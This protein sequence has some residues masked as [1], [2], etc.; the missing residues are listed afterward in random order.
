MPKP[1]V[2]SKA[3]ST[4]SQA[5]G[6]RASTI[7]SR[8][9]VSDSPTKLDMPPDKTYDMC[10][11]LCKEVSE[12]VLHCINERFDAFEAKF[13]SLAASQ[14]ELQ[15][16]MAN[17]EQTASDLDARLLVLEAKCIELEGRNTQLHTKVLDLEARSRRHNIKIVGIQE[18]WG[19]EEGRP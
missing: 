18:S 3:K 11:E 12:S 17:Q 2:S 16:R 4:D 8:G 7:D 13:Q 15:S 9:P 10:K 19:D 6:A 14:A 1:S 5:N